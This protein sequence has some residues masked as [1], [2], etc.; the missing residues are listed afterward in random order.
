MMTL[1]FGTLR[2]RSRGLFRNDDEH[3]FRSPA[4][5]ARLVRAYND[6]VAGKG[7]RF[8]VPQLREEFGLARRGFPLGAATGEIR[9]SGGFS[10]TRRNPS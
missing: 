10:A 1:R 3:L 7:E 4:N 5:A 9:L 6:S 2:V 8:T